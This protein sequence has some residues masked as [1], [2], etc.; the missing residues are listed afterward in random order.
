MGLVEQVGVDALGNAGVGVAH[1]PADLVHGH[2]GAVGHAGKGVAQAVEGDGGQAAFPNKG[3]Q[4]GGKGAGSEG[5]AVG[6]QQQKIIGGTGSALPAALRLEG[7][8]QF[9]QLVQGGD[10][11]RAAAAR[12][13]GGLFHHPASGRSAH[14]AHTE[15]AG[16]EIHIPP[17]Q[18]QDLPPAQAQGAGQPDGHLQVGSPY[19]PEELGQPG[20]GI[21]DRL[22]LD[23]P[24]RGG[25]LDG[26][27]GDD[28]L[29]EG[30]FQ[31]GVEQHVV[32]A[33][34][35]GGEALFRGQP[36]VIAVDKLGGQVGQPHPAQ[37]G[38]NVVAD[39]VLV[40]ADGGVRP[41][42]RNILLHPQL[43]PALQGDAGADGRGGGGERKRHRR[44]GGDGAQNHMAAAGIGLGHGNNSF[45]LF[46]A[47]PGV[48]ITPGCF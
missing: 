40:T 26:A 42:G 28:P 5:Q 6:R 21:V 37:G 41:A 8:Q 45:S 31:G 16:L 1:G 30:G 4:G 43:Q 3:G 20:G 12:G 13:L 48:R 18:A 23:R 2:P 9:H 10:G 17:A 34:R 14:P 33:H 38:D 11:Q 25:P 22:G 47:G 15:L 44:D 7:T 29:A 19:G 35:V 46:P 27:G 32:L 36:L 39:D 24:G